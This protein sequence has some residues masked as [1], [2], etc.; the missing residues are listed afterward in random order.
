MVSPSDRL[1]ANF[2]ATNHAIMRFLE[3]VYEHDLT[4]LKVEYLVYHSLTSLRSIVDGEFIQWVSDT[5]DLEPYRGK[6]I[7][8]VMA[9]M[10][11]STANAIINQPRKTVRLTVGDTVFI[12]KDRK[13]ITLYQSNRRPC[14]GVRVT[15]RL[16]EK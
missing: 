9:H 7:S 14:N 3:R 13:V 4:N 11:D 10:D 16:G 6:I 8:H 5:V 2:T 12:I 1:R 15:V